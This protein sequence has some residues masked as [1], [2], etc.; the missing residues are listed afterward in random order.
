TFFYDIRVDGQDVRS[1]LLEITKKQRA[2]AKKNGHEY[3]FFN[4]Q[5]DDTEIPHCL[6][7]PLSWELYERFG[8]L[9]AVVDRHA[10]EFFPER[11]PNGNFFGRKLGIDA[12]PIEEVIARGETTY[13]NMLQQGETEDEVE[14]TLFQRSEGEHEQLVEMIH[15]LA[16]D[17]RKV[18]SVNI[19]NEG[20]ITGLPADAV[21]EIPAVAAGVGF[22]PMVVPHFEGPMRAYIQRRLASVEITVEAAIK[23]DR[24]LWAEAMMLDGAVTDY[25]VAEQLV[26]DFIAEH[27]DY[28]PQYK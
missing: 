22:C 7:N 28:L 23:G 18:F 8:G 27:K 26:N 6:D 12:F 14:A 11:Y 4:S 20:A 16:C 24:A 21:L 15:S 25:G 19:P 10:S 9:P 13:R 1:Q 3:N 17:E 5:L 2:E